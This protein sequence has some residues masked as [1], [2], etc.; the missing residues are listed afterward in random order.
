MQF[1]F[2]RWAGRRQ[3]VQMTNKS[4]LACKR[5]LNCIGHDTNSTGVYRLLWKDTMLLVVGSNVL[6]FIWAYTLFPMFVCLY[7]CLLLSMTWVQP[8]YI[9][10]QF[11]VVVLSFTSQ[12]RNKRS[13]RPGWSE[14]D[15]HQR[16]FTVNARKSRNRGD[17]FY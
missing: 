17:F 16:T 13:S 14:F 4:F 12:K 7:V 9:G 11:T 1:I 8:L 6:A 2:S 15:S 5:C 3:M 10:N